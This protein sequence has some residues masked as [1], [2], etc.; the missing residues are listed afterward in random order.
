MSKRFLKLQK[1]SLNYA[2][3]YRIVNII[4]SVYK[5][6]FLQIISTALIRWIAVKS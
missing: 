6:I 1:F 2:D 3:F 4:F 5:Y